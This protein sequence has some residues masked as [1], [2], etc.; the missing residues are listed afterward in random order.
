VRDVS[1]NTPVRS[2]GRQ[3]A[4]AKV[5]FPLL[6]FVGIN[7][8]LLVVVVRAAVTLR[9]NRDCNRKRKPSMAL[10]DSPTSFFFFLFLLSFD[11]LP[12]FST[13][14]TAHFP[15]FVPYNEAKIAYD[16]H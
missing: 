10:L 5:C 16:R 15:A 4:S 7:L 1:R 9:P 11:F 13:L 2:S 8:A 6:L 3:C 12:Y 14:S